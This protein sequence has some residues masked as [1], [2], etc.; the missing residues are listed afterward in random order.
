MNNDDGNASL[1]KAIALVVELRETIRLLTL[2]DDASDIM[3]RYARLQ[4]FCDITNQ[5]NLELQIA[6]ALAKYVIVER[7]YLEIMHHNRELENKYE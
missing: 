7:A 4:K 3:K 6:D 5:K 2:P 1:Q